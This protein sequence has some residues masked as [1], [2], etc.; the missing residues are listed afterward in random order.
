MTQ[1]VMLVVFMNGLQ[2][3]YEKEELFI[4]VGSIDWGDHFPSKINQAIQTASAV[5]VIIGPTWLNEL[6]ERAV[7]SKT[8]FVRKEV[9]IA[10]ERATKGG[11][12]IFPILVGGAKIPCI[13]QLHNELK[14]EIGK[15]FEYDA[16]ELPAGIRDWEIISLI[17]F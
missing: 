17:E 15:L 3:F 16:L 10:L 8:D 4:D 5:I 11:V 2:D 9:A 12:A 1:Q 6:N 14:D 13:E 7:K